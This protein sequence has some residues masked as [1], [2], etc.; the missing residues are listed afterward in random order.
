MEAY[1]VIVSVAVFVAPLSVAEIVVLVVDVGFAM[2]TLNV[3]EVFP[4]GMVTETG[5]L[6]ASELELDKAIVV[7]P[8]GA[9]PEIVTVP[10]TED[11]AA[12]LK[13]LEESFNE[14]RAGCRIVSDA[15]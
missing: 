6:A 9:T 7:P 13:A 15:C 14:T 12:P 2:V 11:A 4:A 3:I 5:T 10:V 1:G 8:V